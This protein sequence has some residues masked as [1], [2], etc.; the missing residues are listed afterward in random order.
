[1]P[2]IEDKY[3][4]MAD[5]NETVHLYTVTASSQEE[6]K[7]L[8]D[9]CAAAPSDLRAL[10]EETP[11]LFSPLDREPPKRGVKHRIQVPIEYTL[12]AQHAY[13]LSASKLDA[14]RTQVTELVEKGWVLP[15]ESPW[16]APILFVSKDG[17]KALRMCVDF[18]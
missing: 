1:M 5:E 9:F 2:K 10:V 8:E 3:V 17:G 4:V 6:T 18:P 11:V 16:A 14:M 13:P 7:A 15:S 12:T